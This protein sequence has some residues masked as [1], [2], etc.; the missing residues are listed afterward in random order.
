MTT[1]T[2]STSANQLS[3]VT[4]DDNRILI[5]IG[6]ISITP[7]ILVTFVA[8]VLGIIVIFLLVLLVIGSC[9]LSAERRERIDRRQQVRTALIDRRAEDDKYLP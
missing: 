7:L 2:L 9:R 5:I 6:G 1:K 3:T 8:T 4:N